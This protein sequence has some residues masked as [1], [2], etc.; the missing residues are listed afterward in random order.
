MVHV[1]NTKGTK[2]PPEPLER[3]EVHQLLAACSTRAPTGVRNRA[4][5]AV[6]WRGMLR[7][8]EAISLKPAAYN[9]ATSTIRILEGKG[10]KAR[11]IALNTEAAALLDRWL[12]TR[13]RL[14]LS[15]HRRLFCTL[16]GKPIKDAYVRHL[17]PRL[18]RTAG[19]GKR[20]HAHGLR[21]SGACEMRR[22]GVDS[23]IISKAL[24]HASIATTEIYTKVSDNSLV[25]AIERADTLA[26]VDS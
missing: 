22:A 26:Q 11:T 7:C 8:N 13:V 2:L 23:G 19:L 6:L 3:E 24:G 20:V 25:S 15:N 4:L 12:D 10:Q 14:G 1:G 5:V 18:A 17:L 21:H 9:P 16:P